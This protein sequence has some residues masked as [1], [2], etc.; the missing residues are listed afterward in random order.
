MDKDGKDLMEKILFLTVGGSP[1]PNVTAI[2]RLE[3]DYIFFICTK[4]NV[5]TGTTHCVDGEGYFDPKTKNKTSEN[6]IKLTNYRKEYEKIEIDDPDDLNEIIEK[7]KKAIKKAKESKPKEII[8]D[9]TGGTK[10]MSCGLVSLACFDK[11][12]K[13]TLTK[14]TRVDYIKTQD[15]S[16]TE[17]VDL[18]YPRVQ[19]IIE[20][21][22]QMLES[23][24]YTSAKT[25]I[26]KFLAMEPLN[27][28]LRTKLEDIHKEIL[29]F[30]KWDKFNHKEAFECFKRY[31]KIEK[32]KEHFDFLLKIVKNDLCYELLFD[33]IKNAE[34]KA[35][36]K[37]YDDAVARIY[38]CI[39]LFLQIRLK[40]KFGINTSKLELKKIPEKIREEY[41]DKEKI[42]LFE[43]YELL[44][45]IDDELKEVLSKY[46]GEIMDKISI[47]NKSILAHGIIAITEREYNEI[48]KS[49]D[50]FI[51]ECFKNINEN[52]NYPPDFIKNVEL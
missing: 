30:E 31:K 49:F 35:E 20:I 10:T 9:Y 24:L 48:K 46:K 27:R 6:L 5:G 36:N 19:G 3:P 18:C 13:L 34:R 39:E 42:S 25:V 17:I 47:R 15:E 22:N 2:N 43:A 11:S 1:E 51:Q 33:L 21:V 7:T 4:G 8:L 41:K 23:N 14:G 40:N 50:I 32:Y 44:E 12:L 29:I 38:R 16:I 37:N 45:K 52:I 28:D 26:E